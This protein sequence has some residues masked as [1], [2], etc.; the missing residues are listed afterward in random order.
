LVFF[1][2][3][4]PIEE[5]RKNSV[6]SVSPVN[7]V[8]GWWICLFF[9]SRKTV[10]MNNTLSIRSPY[11][12]HVV[13]VAPEIHWNTG[14]IGRTCLGTGSVLHLIEPLGFSLENKRV[15]RAGLDYWPHVDV[16]TW[17]HFQ[18][19][20]EA[21]SPAEEEICLFTKQ[22]SRSFWDMP[23]VDRMFL[24]FGSETKGLPPDI[25]ARYPDARYCIPMTGAIRSLNLSTAVGIV[26]YE[27]LR[28]CIFPV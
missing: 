25:L 22:G 7:E 5:K 6:L 23:P 24:V 4:L 20:F 16:R 11:E 21:M 1:N 12:R 27:S 9:A 19:F 17:N 3:R 14:N 18:A 10:T 15:K 26:L 8:N 2:C 28:S 13:L